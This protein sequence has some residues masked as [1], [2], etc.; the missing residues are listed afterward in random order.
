VNRFYQTQIRLSESDCLNVSH[1]CFKEG[2]LIGADCVFNITRPLDCEKWRNKRKETFLAGRLAV[3]HAQTYLN[4]PAKDIPKAEDGSPLWPNEYT[5][6]ISHTDNQA[7]AVLLPRSQGDIQYIGID[8]EQLDNADK[9]DAADL[10]GCKEEFEIL[11]SAGIEKAQRALLLFSLKESVYKALY[12]A[13]GEYFDFLD[14]V[15]V[16][17]EQTDVFVFQVRR[18]LSRRIKSGYLVKGRYK[19]LGGHVMTWAYC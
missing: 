3:R 11:A 2:S 15:L 9:L 7:V 16:S 4:E 19:I 10:I 5:G 13:V 1:F 8:L 17:I 18:T 6:S 14:V 12:P